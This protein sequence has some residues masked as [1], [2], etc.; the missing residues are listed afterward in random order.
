MQTHVTALLGGRVV[1]EAY[2]RLNQ[3]GKCRI[4]KKWKQEITGD[5]YSAGVWSFGSWTD[6]IYSPHPNLT[7]QTSH[8]I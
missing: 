4:K 5:W 2:F 8:P 3:G 6:N 7:P 1:W